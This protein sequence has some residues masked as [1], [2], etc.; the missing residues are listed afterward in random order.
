M[1]YVSIDIETTGLEPA[2]DQ[3]LEFAAVADDFDSPI[4]DL[5]IFQRYIKWDRVRGNPFAMSMNAE[6]LK[7]I[8]NSPIG[9]A[10]TLRTTGC[11]RDD[12]LLY[13]FATWLK[14][15]Q[16][17][18]DFNPMNLKVAGHNASG[19]DVQFIKRL[20]G[21]GEVVQFHH[22]VLDVGSLYFRPEDH[23]LPATQKCLTRAG[24]GGT[25]LEHRAVP[26]ALNAVKLIRAK[27]QA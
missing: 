11:V 14:L 6:I 19:F 12:Q 21:Y 13:Q 22:R 23:E 25:P 15:L 17:D 16:D 18:F 9:F 1:N 10:G 24:L 4:D 2:L 26:D 20:P 8:S 5:P 7:T 3:I 27:Y